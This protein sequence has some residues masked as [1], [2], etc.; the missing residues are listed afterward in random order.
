MRISRLHVKNFRSILD[1]AI[2]CESLTALVGKNGSGKSSFLAALELFYSPRATVTREDFHAGDTS[3]NVEIAVTFSDLEAQAKESFADYIRDGVLEVTKVLPV[4]T[5]GTCY[6][7][8]LRYPGFDIVRGAGGKRE[9]NAAYREFRKSAEWTHLPSASSAD[10]VEAALEKWEAEHADECVPARDTGQYFGFA[11]GAVGSLTPYTVFLRIPA[12]RD[13]AEDGLEGRGSAIT[14]L[15]DFVVRHVLDSRAEVTQFREQ[16]QAE[17]E[18][19]VYPTLRPELEA[20]EATLSNTLS[21]FAPSSEL[22]LHWSDPPQIHIPDPQA[23]VRVAEDGYEASIQRTGHGLQRAFI[24]TMLQH[25]SA[26][27][28]NSKEEEDE[29]E[30]PSGPTLVLGIDE[31]ELYQHPSRQRHLAAILRRLATGDAQGVAASTQ[32]LYTTH[33]PLFIGLDWFD[34]I[35]VLRKVP[36][37]NRGPKVSDAH[38]VNLEDFAK[39]IEAALGK[40]AGDFTGETFRARLASIMTPWMNEGFFAD[41]VVLVEGED[42]RAAILGAAKA[43]EVDF[44]SIGVAVI[45]CSGKTSID[46]P[47][48]IF[49]HLAIPVYVV[50]DGDRGKD[51]NNGKRDSRAQTNRYLCR[52][53][54]RTEED[55]PLFVGKHAAC[56]EMDLE[57]TLRDEIGGHFE[58]YREEAQVELGLENQNLKNPKLVER[59]LESAAKDGISSSSLGTIVNRVVALQREAKAT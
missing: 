23:E 25:L 27:S 31:P 48:V 49:R 15:M 56:F 32:V 37:G 1:Q 4:D 57:T 21:S 8:R 41:V 46:R 26:A 6:G 58:T 47:L 24:F 55:W 14:Q 3:E 28:E 20:L 34:Q 9:V 19:V 38:A 35:R 42:D 59:I 33:S 39:E 45:P 54:G 11:S 18:N 43:A 44:D 22:V 16:T 2:S 30:T 5:I 36:A 53:L 52:L 29:G 17:Y 51:G 12:V 13:A 7:V 10:A 50:W 40:P